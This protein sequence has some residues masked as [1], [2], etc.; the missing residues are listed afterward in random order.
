V[1]VCVCVCICHIC[2]YIHQDTH[3]HTHT[4]T[5]QVLREILTYWQRGS[6]TAALKSAVASKDDAVLC[7]FLGNVY[8]QADIWTMDHFLLL[9][10]TIIRLLDSES[11]EC[12]VIALQ[13]AQVLALFFLS[14]ALDRCWFFFLPCR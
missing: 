11:E 12:Q 13:T 14:A 4:H 3:T 7:G 6:V 9:L 5:M 8:K 1:C 2:T 10:P